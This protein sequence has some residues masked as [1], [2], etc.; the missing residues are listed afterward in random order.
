M[1]LPATC[2]AMVLP[3][4]HRIPAA[5]IAAATETH[6][7]GTGNDNILVQFGLV[8]VC[9]LDVANVFLRVR[10][11]GRLLLLRLMMRVLLLLL[12][13]VHLFLLLLRWW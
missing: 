2:A 8:G 4:A 12:I 5:V 7:A 10:A 3:T 11:Q 13:L 6:I 9:I 1:M